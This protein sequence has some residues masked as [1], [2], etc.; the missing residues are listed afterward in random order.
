MHVQIAGVEWQLQLK[1]TAFRDQ[2]RNAPHV[3]Q[4]LMLRVATLLIEALHG[5][6]APLANFTAWCFWDSSR[7][8]DISHAH[9]RLIQFSFSLIC[10]LRCIRIC[11][12]S[13]QQAVSI[14]TAMNCK[15][16]PGGAAA[17][18]SCTSSRPAHTDLLQC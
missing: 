16:V 1:C 11:T 14:R 2:F 17:C 15:P 12:A 10:L 4:A 5:T 9:T 8:S 3:N 7:L 6:M 13:T 18:Y